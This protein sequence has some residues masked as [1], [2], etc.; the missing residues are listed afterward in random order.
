MFRLVTSPRESGPGIMKRTKPSKLGRAK[1]KPPARKTAKKNSHMKP[2]KELSKPRSSA[3]KA[4]AKKVPAAPIKKAPGKSPSKNVVTVVA[5]KS[6]AQSATANDA[7]MLTEWHDDIGVIWTRMLDLVNHADTFGQVFAIIRALDEAGRLKDEIDWTFPDWILDAAADSITIRI[8]Q[9][10]DN[11][12]RNHSLLLLLQKVAENSRLLTR[13]RYINIQCASSVDETSR[14]LTARSVDEMFTEKFGAAQMP[15]VPEG[16]VRAQ[17]A[18]LK[19]ACGQVE[20][21]ANQF[22]AHLSKKPSGQPLK[23]LGLLRS[24]QQL[25]EVVIFAKDC[26][27][28]DDP[29]G[30]LVSLKGHW[31]RVFRFPW[32]GATDEPPEYAQIFDE[33]GRKTDLRQFAQRERA[34]SSP[35]K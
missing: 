33:F 7:A 15:H 13:H 35:R 3:K 18:K 17:I 29:T 6:A 2:A 34:R 32:L 5:P 22:V 11:N 25:V 24:L 31:T 28:A 19:N 1:A 20:N 23:Y 12:P 10:S 14:R 30:P 26:I 21:Y 9:F 8:R 4:A 16:M 27:D